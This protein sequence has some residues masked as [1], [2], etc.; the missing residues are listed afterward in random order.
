MSVFAAMRRQPC[1][2]ISERIAGSVI[3]LPIYNDMTTDEC[4][5]IV[6]AFCRIR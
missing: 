1:L 6:E 4:D 3:A 2:P 5:G